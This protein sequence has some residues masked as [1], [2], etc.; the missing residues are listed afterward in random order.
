MVWESCFALRNPE[1]IIDVWWR[2]RGGCNGCGCCGCC[3]CY[4]GCD[5][6]SCG[7]L[8]CLTIIKSTNR[9]IDKYSTVA[10][11]EICQFF[12]GSD[13]IGFLKGNIG[14]DINIDCGEIEDS[15][16]T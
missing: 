2:R 13:N 12:D 10:F 14:R 15:F 9:Q 6:L 4:G 11:Y 8:I 16:D 7:H 1:W 3:G 5:G